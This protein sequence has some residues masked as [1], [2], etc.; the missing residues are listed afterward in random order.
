MKIKLLFLVIFLPI[1]LCAQSEL[2]EKQILEDYDV[3]KNVLTGSHPSMYEYTTKSQ[4]DSIFSNFESELKNIKNSEDLF[5]SISALALNVRDGHLMILHPKM[6]SIPAMFPLLLKIIDEKLY[7][8]TEDFGIPLG[9]ELISIDSLNSQEILKSMFKYATSD[10]YNVTK[11]YRQIESEFGILLYYE[12]GAK[13]DYTVTY[14]TPDNQTKTSKVQSQPFQSIGIRNQNRSSNFS[15]YQHNKDKIE[16]ST[17]FIMQ[18]LPFAYFIDSIKTAVLTVNSFGIDPREFKSK[19]IEIFEEIKRKKG[20]S[21]IIDVRQNNGGY[22]ANA[23]TLFSFI[24]DEP[25]KQR[26]SES[27]ITSDLIEQDYIINTMSD[28]AEFFK[29]YFADSERKDGRW[30]LTTDRAEEMMKPYKQPFKG[31][32]YVLIGGNTFSAGSEFALNVKNST[33]KNLFGE[34]TGGGYYFHTGQFPVLYELP[35]SKIFMNLSLIRINHYV[36]DNSVPKGSGILPDF[37]INLTQ[38]DLING[39]DLQLDYVVK[40]IGEK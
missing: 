4:W 20:T 19:L 22:R 11:K 16:H 27:A 26:I 1:A 10:G 2:T 37:E 7:A 8:D 23:I 28:Y 38:K 36:K 35:N 31:K 15:A 13:N 39:K 29:N 14:N 6:D 33:Q 25:F 34:E 5:K 24:S 30:I 40:K 9:S 3:F 21:L 17:N 32:T 18:K 12:L